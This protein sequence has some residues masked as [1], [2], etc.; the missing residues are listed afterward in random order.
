MPRDY[1]YMFSTTQQSL[2]CLSAG[3]G[4]MPNGIDQNTGLNRAVSNA[5]RLGWV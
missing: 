4:L 1:V 5:F 2:Q 3:V